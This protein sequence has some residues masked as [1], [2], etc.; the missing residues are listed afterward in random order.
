MTPVPAQM[1]LEFIMW[2]AR[3]R[4]DVKSLRELSKAKLLHLVKN[5][6]VQ[7][8]ETNRSEDEWEEGFRLLET[9]EP[10]DEYNQIHRQLHLT[11]RRW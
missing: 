11:N 10:H 2:V 5:F 9:R 8:V 1:M 3:F 4:P 7:K 6:E